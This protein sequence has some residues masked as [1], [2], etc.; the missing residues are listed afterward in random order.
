VVA[1]ADPFH[2]TVDPLRNPDPFTVKINADPPA[3]TEF[4]L[5]LEIVA[6]GGLIVN[7]AEPKGVPP[8]LTAVTLALPTLAIRPADTDAVSCVPLR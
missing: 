4:G 2:S 7:I 6:G 1:N 8:G 3:A 5:R